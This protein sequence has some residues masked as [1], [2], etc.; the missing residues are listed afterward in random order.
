MTEMSLY[1]LLKFFGKTQEK[2]AQDLGVSL[3]TVS[4]WLNKKRKPLPLH[5]KRIEEVLDEYK[6]ERQ[7][8]EKAGAA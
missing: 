8:Q 7:S 1:E 3:G 2:F 5:Q 4:R 6:K